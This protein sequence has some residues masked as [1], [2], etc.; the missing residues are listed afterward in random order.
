MK[1]LD[2][3]VERLEAERDA[4]I[5]ACHDL[6]KALLCLHGIDF[7]RWWGRRLDQIGPEERRK[8]EDLLET[9]LMRQSLQSSEESRHG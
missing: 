5:W 3:R 2:R 8:I 1:N 6:S 4:R 9:A 7:Q